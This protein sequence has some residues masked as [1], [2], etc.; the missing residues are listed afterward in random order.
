LIL[1]LNASRVNSIIKTNFSD[2][3]YEAFP[4]LNNHPVVSILC[5]F[6]SFLQQCVEWCPG[7]EKEIS[8]RA[9]PAEIPSS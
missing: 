3:E 2:Y 8:R 5:S 6:L 4:L 1:L 7:R 9:E